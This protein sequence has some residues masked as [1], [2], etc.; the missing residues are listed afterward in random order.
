MS[1]SGS[2]NVLSGVTLICGPRRDRSSGGSYCEEHRPR[3]IV[4]SGSSIYPRRMT[5]IYRLYRL[6]F[7]PPN[8]RNRASSSL[9]PIPAKVAL[10]NRQPPFRLGGRNWSSCPITC[11]SQYPSGPAQLGGEQS[12]LLG[13]KVRQPSSAP[14]RPYH[15]RI[16]IPRI[17]TAYLSS[18]TSSMRQPLKRLLTIKVSPLT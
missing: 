3:Q 8:A 16:D 7:G 10:P 2:A 1:R 15:N 9:P 6:D 14:R 4:E 17:T 11:R 18:Q 12:F 5:A 13:T